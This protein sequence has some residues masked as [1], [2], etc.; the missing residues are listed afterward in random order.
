MPINKAIKAS[1][2][3]D[4]RTFR[5]N[6]DSVR[7]R[8]TKV[9]Q[10]RSHIAAWLILVTIIMPSQVNIYLWGETGKFTPG[11]LAI[12][13]LLLP[14]VSK[15]LEK[16]RHVI[17]SDIFI[18]ALSIW[19]VGSRIPQ[20]GLN[21][22]AVAETIEFC[23][24]YIVA[25]GYFFGPP[26]LITFTQVLK[27]IIVFL[28]LL[29]ILDPLLDTN[30][31]W[32]QQP[33][34]Y[35]LGVVRAAS[36]FDGAEMNGAF[37]AACA[38]VFLY[39]ERNNLKRSIWVALC[40]F[41]CVLA[42]SSGPLLSFIVILAVYY[43]DKSLNQ[44]HWRWKAFGSAIA[45]FLIAVQVFAQHPISW[46]VSHLTLDPQT[47]FFRLYVFDHM[48]D[49]IASS[50]IVGI[51]FG[52]IGSDENFFSHVSV[53]STYIVYAM[54]FGIPMLVFLSLA[55]FS[56][57]LRYSS[58]SNNAIADPFVTRVGTGFTL[59]FMSLALTGLTVHIFHT[60]WMF[61]G[62]LVG[63]RGSIKEFSNLSGRP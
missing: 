44:F 47:G 62:L 3:S 50:P 8:I 28:A 23:G 46:I 33:P 61:W 16:G 26:A 14:A 19:M 25:R 40:L 42:L 41:G 13:F 59:A 4:R 55:N 30:V 5:P 37:F 63:I 51:G 7:V 21:P 58:K 49:L 6:D 20:D 43:Y 27:V 35:R 53:D 9:I 48:I 34:Q 1:A 45:G 36:M 29:S 32:H 31:I 10:G 18:V 54:R 12:V 24:A 56:S 38:P 22:S 2:K 15:L 17:A 57:F 11:R 60:N 39:S 52:P